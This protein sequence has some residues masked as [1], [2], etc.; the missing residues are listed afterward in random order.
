MN[1]PIQEIL[2]KKSEIKWF[3]NLIKS[4]F[5]ADPFGF[6]IDGK[7]M[8]IFKDYSKILRRERF[9]IAEFDW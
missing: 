8:I 9:A 7:K 1:F 3:S 5:C 6:E 2:Q 4:M